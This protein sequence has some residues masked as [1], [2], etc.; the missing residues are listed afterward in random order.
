MVRKTIGRYY[1]KK[2]FATHHISWIGFA[3]FQKYTLTLELSFCH[4]HNENN[5]ADDKIKEGKMVV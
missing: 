1:T 4:L 2:D 3:F 5:C